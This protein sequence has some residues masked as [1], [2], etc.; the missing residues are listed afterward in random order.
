MYKKYYVVG[1]R[2]RGL[3]M[4]SLGSHCRH[5]PH[6]NQTIPHAYTGTNFYPDA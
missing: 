1:S 2:G 6:T 3:R 5:K 4:L